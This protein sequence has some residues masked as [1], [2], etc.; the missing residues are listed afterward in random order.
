[1]L[2]SRKILVLVVAALVTCAMVSASGI[3][4]MRRVSTSMDDVANRSVPALVMT[5][6]LR[7]SYLS[8]IPLVYQRAMNADAQ[9]GSDQAKHIEEEIDK[10]VDQINKYATRTHDEEELK[11]LDEAKQGLGA[12]IAKMQQV[13]ALA[14]AGENKMALDAIER[15]IVGLHRS[16]SATFDKLV[17]FNLDHANAVVQ[18]ADAA[19]RGATAI[20]ITACIVGLAAIAALGAFL[21]RSITRPLADMERGIAKTAS[22][23]D[24]TRSLPVSSDDEIGRTL[25]AYNGLVQKLRSSFGDIQQ[26]STRM[27]S[28]ADEVSKRSHEITENS[29]TQSDAA[30]DMAAAVEELTV[31]ISMVASQAQGAAGTTR[32]SNARAD[33]G[34]EVIMEAVQGIQSISESVKGAAT[35]I[36]ALRN[37]SESISSVANII[38]EIADQTNLL[39]LNAAIEAARAGE[40]GRGFAVVADEVRKLAERTSQST[41]E[42]SSLLARMQGNAREAVDSMGHVVKEVGSGVDNARRAGESISGIKDASSEVVH[43]V[44]E[45]SDAV[46]EQSAASTSIAQRIEK[47]AQMTDRNRSAAEETA[48]S[49]ERMH[50]MSNTIARALAIYRV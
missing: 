26:A 12:F 43:A 6:D 37:D 3:F 14:K 45:I 21:G 33:Q 41:Q 49:I 46:S 48:R 28:I 24:F 25:A 34:S 38:R 36:D 5:S 15:S 29:T 18:T 4:G 32:E 30:S 10:L 39:A 2:I 11:V 47:I 13:N 31:S 44:G 23:L 1:M 50:E 22:E 20:G 8:I 19:S 40:Q 17:K 35:R 7:A 9:S 42:I 16:L 27:L